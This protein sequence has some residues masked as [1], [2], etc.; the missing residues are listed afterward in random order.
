MICLNSSCFAVLLLLLPS[1]SFAHV[2]TDSEVKKVERLFEI[3]QVDAFVDQQIDLMV[4]HLT[5]GDPKLAAH[6]NEFKT[7]F[8]E[9]TNLATQKK[10]MIDAYLHTFSEAEIDEMIR[11][12][13]SALGQKILKNVPE[14]SKR[15]M[16][17]MQTNLQENQ[18]KIE[19]LYIKI[20]SNDS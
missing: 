5:Q 10:H 9:I 17:H 4:T 16:V 13:E 11:F 19:D 20:A 18:K 6:K 8:V 12:N 15:A 7:L 1:L 2:Y 14:L 3:S